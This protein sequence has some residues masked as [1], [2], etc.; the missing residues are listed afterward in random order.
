[1]RRQTRRHRLSGLSQKEF[2]EKLPFQACPLTGYIFAEKD[3]Q[4]NYEHTGNYYDYYFTPVG[5]VK[6]SYEVIE[7]LKNLHLKIVD[8]NY[9]LA[10][11]S[12][13]KYEYLQDPSIINNEFI[14]NANKLEFPRSFDEKVYYLLKLLY[15]TGGNEYKTRT[16]NSLY[17]YTLAYA[18]HPE[19]FTRIIKAL[20]NE[21][22][23]EIDKVHALG[24]GTIVHYVGVTLTKHGR[25][26][27]RGKLPHD[28]LAPIVN[29]NINTGDPT[30]DEKIIHAKKLFYKEYATL[31]DRRSACKVLAD[32]AEPL[33]KKLDSFFTNQDIKV[34]F[35]MVNDFDIRHNADYTKRLEYIEQIEWVFYTFLNTIRAYY[36]LDRKY[37]KTN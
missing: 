33:K 22:W 12:R 18:E 24:G 8:N 36:F 11:Y 32:V 19:Q 23:I 14:N 2:L 29:S 37:G 1:M 31:E 21:N 3:L 9:I 26:E 20:E 30:I 34:F 13:N 7:S 28:P 17:D 27:I 16:L 6:I 4:F 5:K 25:D 15:D 10:G 35:Q